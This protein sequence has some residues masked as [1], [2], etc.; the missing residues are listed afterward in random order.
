MIAVPILRDTS[1]SVCA[2]SCHIKWSAREDTVES[3][4]SIGGSSLT[5]RGARGR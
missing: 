4:F 3:V 2:D 5:S 1:S